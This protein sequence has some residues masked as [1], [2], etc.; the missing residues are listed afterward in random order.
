MT[1]C[2]NPGRSMTDA[3]QKW[4]A[5]SAPRRSAP[6]RRSRHRALAVRSREVRAAEAERLE[7][8]L[9]FRDRHEQFPQE[10]AAMIL[11]HGDDRALADRDVSVGVPVLLLTEALDETKASPDTVAEILI[12]VPQCRHGLPRC[13]G[14]A[15]QGRGGSDDT[16]VVF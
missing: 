14:E 15:R 8:G 13:V 4:P 3:L 16:A 7:P 1:R 12:E 11:D 2:P 10:R 5:A 9:D 6:A